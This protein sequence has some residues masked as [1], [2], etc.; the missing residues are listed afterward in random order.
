M[1]IRARMKLTGRL[2]DRP[3]IQWKSLAFATHNS[4]DHGL[5][6]AECSSLHVHSYPSALAMISWKAASMSA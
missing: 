1:T 5:A 6:A 2:L 4:P 3:A